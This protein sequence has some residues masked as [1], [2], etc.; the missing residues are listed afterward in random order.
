[1]V[2]FCERAAHSVDSAFFY[3][4]CLFV[5]L[6]ISRFGCPGGEFGSD[7]TNSWSLL[8]SHFSVVTDKIDRNKMVTAHISF[9]RSIQSNQL[10]WVR[11]RTQ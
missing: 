8:I 11:P 9:Y 3:K 4:L 1:M 10:L 2:T 5:I 6:V 7:C